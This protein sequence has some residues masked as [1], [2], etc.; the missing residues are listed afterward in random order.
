MVSIVCL[1]IYFTVIVLIEYFVL[2]ADI[3]SP[4]FLYLASFLLCL[5]AAYILRVEWD[6][7]YLSISTAWL[8]A[9]SALIVV[10]IDCVARASCSAM[11]RG[12]C[13]ELTIINMPVFLVQ[14][15]IAINLLLMVWSLWKSGALFS[16][17]SALNSTMAAYKETI[18]YGQELDLPSKVVSQIGKIMAVL[19]YTEAFVIVNNSAVLK[20]AGLKIGRQ[21]KLLLVALVASYFLFRLFFRSSRQSSIFLVIGVLTMYYICMTSTS[22]KKEKSRGRWKTVFLLLIVTAIALVA[23]YFLGR[24]VGRKVSDTPLDAA[25]GYLAT[26]VLGLNDIVS[27]GFASTYWGEKTFVGMG[28]IFH[29]LGIWPSGVENYSMLPFF[30]HGNTVSILGRWYWDFDFT[31]ALII[32][33]VL[34]TLFSFFY[35]GFVRSNKDGAG[36]VASI[37][38]YCFLVHIF[39]FAGYDDFSFNIWTTNYFIQISL[40]ILIILLIFDSWRISSNR[41]EKKN[42]D[43][44]DVYSRKIIDKDTE[45]LL[46]AKETAAG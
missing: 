4:A 36:R 13:E 23:F 37:V 41:Y 22:N 45:R 19:T 25:V 34:V 17:G 10:V 11:K 35:Y 8:L 33:A 26:G 15:T 30:R 44:S 29:L 31:G 42:R 1:I 40:F 2:K 14:V 5:W 32:L 27:Y 28:D 43:A 38:I 20:R 3:T 9:V 6:L 18:S 7:E 46:K 21:S 39:Y 16:F 12:G 24:I